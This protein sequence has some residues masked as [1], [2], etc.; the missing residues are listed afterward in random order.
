MTHGHKIRTKALKETH[1]IEYIPLFIDEDAWIAAGSKIL[2]NNV[3]II[4]RGA[5]VEAGAIVTKDVDDWAIVA[6]NPARIIGSRE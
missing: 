1:D 6:G 2:H 3:K 4:G 5:L